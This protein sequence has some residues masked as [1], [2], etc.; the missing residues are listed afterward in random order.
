MSVSVEN[1][2]NQNGHAVITFVDHLGQRYSEGLFVPGA[3]TQAQ[4]DAH[5]AARAASI[6]EALAEGE[7]QQVIA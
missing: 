3:W 6:A 5:A 1:I 7:A 2:V 4:L